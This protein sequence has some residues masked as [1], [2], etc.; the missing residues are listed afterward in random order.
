MALELEFIHWIILILAA[1]AVVPVA[2]TLAAA[3]QTIP[4][5]P[6]PGGAD[7]GSTPAICPSNP[8]VAYEI[9]LLRLE[10]RAEVGHVLKLLD[11][12][13]LWVAFPRRCEHS[14]APIHVS[15]PNF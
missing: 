7:C 3:D 15:R 8:L 2:A 6:W 12:N 5:T 1:L 10:Q 13:L 9:G 4:P 14:I 11:R